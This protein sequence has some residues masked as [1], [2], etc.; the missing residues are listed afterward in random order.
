MRVHV[1][2]LAV[3]LI[4]PATRA[5]KVMIIL[6]LKPKKPTGRGPKYIPGKCAKCGGEVFEAEVTLDDCYNVWGGTCPHCKATNLLSTKHGRGYDSRSMDLVLPTAEEVTL[7]P[8][9]PRDSP[10]QVVK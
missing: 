3:A 7:N 10:V 9:L 1:A 4:A 6:D 8:E 5:I 2:G